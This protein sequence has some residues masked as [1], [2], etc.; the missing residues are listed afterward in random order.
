M[1]PELVKNGHNEMNEN[2]NKVVPSVLINVKYTD[3][4]N[5]LKF[6]FLLQLLKK[7]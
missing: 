3:K 6:F 4:D 2:I 1:L 5:Q 7:L